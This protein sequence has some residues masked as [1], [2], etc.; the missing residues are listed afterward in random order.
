MMKP[1]KV[2]LSMAGS[3]DEVTCY[4]LSIYLKSLRK[5]KKGMTLVEV[6]RATGIS[7]SYLSQLE[8]GKRGVPSVRILRKLSECYGV[9]LSKLVG[10]IDEKV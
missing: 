10:V 7:N 5:I 6:E 3:Y 8:T 9:K 2:K 1:Q 4:S